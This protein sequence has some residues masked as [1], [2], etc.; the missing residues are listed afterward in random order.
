MVK[1]NTIKKT[2]PGSTRAPTG[3]G[4]TR[5]CQWH[6]VHLHHGTYKDV[7]LAHS[8][9]EETTFPS[10]LHLSPELVRAC[11][12]GWGDP[13]RNTN[14]FESH[15]RLRSLRLVSKSVG[16]A[17]LREVH[18]HSLH[19]GD[20]VWIGEG[21]AASCSMPSVVRLLSGCHLKAL[22]V[23]LEG[24]DEEETEEGVRRSG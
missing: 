12:P 11:I 8:M 2:T 22:Y 7:R 5:H 19:L 16:Q 21:D 10:L 14:S 17:A 3:L 4:P 1:R 23:N 18:L 6:Q 13:L 15:E 24:Q 20:E 9:D